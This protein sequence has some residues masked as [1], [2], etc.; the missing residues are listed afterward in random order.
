MSIYPSIPQEE[1]ERRMDHV[2]TIARDSP[3]SVHPD[4]KVTAIIFDEKG[5]PISSYRKRRFGEPHSEAKVIIKAFQ[6]IIRSNSAKTSESAIREAKILLENLKK[7]VSTPRSIKKESDLKSL[8]RISALLHYPLKKSSMFVN[9]EPC[10]HF[11]KN[12][13]C[14]HLIIGAGI[15]SVYFA[16]YDPDPD[17]RGKGERILK[18]KGIMVNRGCR[19]VEALKLNSVFYKICFYMPK[20]FG[21]IHPAALP[22][23]TPAYTML[24]LFVPKADV[25]SNNYGKDVNIHTFGMPPLRH[26]VKHLRR[27]GKPRISPTRFQEIPID[28]DC[29]LFTTLLNP[30]AIIDMIY[31]Y[32]KRIP[33]AIV[34]AIPDMSFEFGKEECLEMINE[35]MPTCDVCVGVRLTEISDKLARISLRRRI[36][37][38]RSKAGKIAILVLAKGISYSKR[39]RVETRYVELVSA[40]T[41]HVSRLEEYLLML[42][43]LKEDI[44]V[45]LYLAGDLLHEKWRENTLE[46]FK[47]LMKRNKSISIWCMEEEVVNAFKNA[48]IQRTNYLEPYWEII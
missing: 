41:L 9:L 13:S 30:I 1:A 10:S 14:A 3:F 31:K 42:R 11:G 24:G 47:K 26:T 48:R 40:T 7:R 8:A 23:K 45:N 32:F 5:M 18:E 12:P 6:T 15:K 17:V 37:V 46:N 44:K 38:E 33:S 16:S 39:G 4:P 21:G 27:S 25:R 34:A 19:H 2:L 29:I 36:S 22:Q 43:F 28:K 35:Y 20:L